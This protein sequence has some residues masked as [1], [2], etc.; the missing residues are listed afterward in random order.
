[1]WGYC[2]E[3][4]WWDG[5]TH[6]GIPWGSWYVNSG[7]FKVPHSGRG[8]VVA[9]EWTARDLHATYHTGSPVIYSTDPN[10]VLRAGLCTGENIDYWKHLFDEYLFNTDHN[11]QVFFSSSSRKAMRW[12]SQTGSLYSRLPMSRNVQGMLDLFFSTILP[13]ILLP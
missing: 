13:A 10:D 9:C 7:S 6:K 5:I 2:Y 12:S 4:F 3:Q 1:M 8:Q 11:G